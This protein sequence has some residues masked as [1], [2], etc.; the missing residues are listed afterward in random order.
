M[1]KGTRCLTS[2]CHHKQELHGGAALRQPHRDT[3]GSEVSISILPPGKE[4][5]GTAAPT[6]KT[7]SSSD[8][9]SRRAGETQGEDPGW[10]RL[11][12]GAGRLQP[13]FHGRQIH[14]LQAHPAPPRCGTEQHQCRGSPV[15]AAGAEAVAQ[16]P[17]Y[18]RPQALPKLCSSPC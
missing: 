5:V 15:S 11:L 4:L 3:G 7:S 12:A 17:F 13:L 2:P 18:S 10:P 6:L 9:S 8:S 14:Q 16:E 1:G